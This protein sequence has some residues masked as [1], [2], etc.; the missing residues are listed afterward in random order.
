LK[1]KTVTNFHPNERADHETI[2]EFLA[3]SR[4]SPEQ[5]EW[6][7]SQP[8]HGRPDLDRL[9]AE[10]AKVGFDDI[11]LQLSADRER[12]SF[13]MRLTERGVAEDNDALLRSWI[14]AL[15]SAGFRVGFEEVGVADVEG[16]L[17]SGNALTGPLAE[18][19]EQGAPHIGT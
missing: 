8:V 15:R 13:K 11:D 19:C 7:Q 9:R 12:L 4:L 2:A 5:I 1:T 6:A 3:R 18:I 14:M 17:I 10:L 16:D